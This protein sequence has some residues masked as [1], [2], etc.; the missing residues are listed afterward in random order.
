MEDYDEVEYECTRCHARVSEFGE[1]SGGRFTCEQ[2]GYA[3]Y[4]QDHDPAPVK[5]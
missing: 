4:L 3:A 1:D 2:F 5:E